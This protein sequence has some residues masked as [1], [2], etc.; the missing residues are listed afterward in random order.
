[1]ATLQHQDSFNEG[2]WLFQYVH[3]PLFV[4]IPSTMPTKRAV[5]CLPLLFCCCSSRL[6]YTISTVVLSLLFR[7]SWRIAGRY[8]HRGGVSRRNI[9]YEVPETHI[10][11]SPAV[12]AASYL[13]VNCRTVPQSETNIG[14]WD[15]E[16]KPLPSDILAWRLFF[17]PNQTFKFQHISHST[18]RTGPTVTQ[19]GYLK[20]LQMRLGEITAGTS[21]PT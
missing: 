14:T 15:L 18:K 11:G 7:N 3:C 10:S 13:Y 19:G 4:S 2:Q 17:W 5:G 9:L 21:S 20:S 1:M 8:F 16:F 6:C 12:T